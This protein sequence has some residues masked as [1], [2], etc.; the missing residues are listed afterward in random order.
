VNATNQFRGT[1][2]VQFLDRATEYQVD[3]I[4]TIGEPNRILLTFK[5]WPMW[6]KRGVYLG[7]GVWKEQLMQAEDDL[8]Q[9]PAG[10]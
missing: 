9:R 5:N 4:A 8:I 3:T 2:A 10:Q 6:D 7:V 1:L